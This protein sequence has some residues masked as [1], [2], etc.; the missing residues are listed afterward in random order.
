[1]QN[2]DARTQMTVTVFVQTNGMYDYDTYEA[3]NR[4]SQ[5]IITRTANRM[6]REAVQFGRAERFEKC[7]WH[8]FSSAATQI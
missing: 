2:V 1:M 5:S 3:V 4:K 7:V 8:I 6:E